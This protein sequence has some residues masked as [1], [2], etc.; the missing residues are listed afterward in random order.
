VIEF[1]DYFQGKTI[2]VTGGTGSIG[3]EIVRQLIQYNPRQIRVY[4]RDEYKQFDMQNNLEVP[5]GARVS[6]LLGDVR[7]KERLFMATEG[8]DII[9]HTAALKHVPYC[10]Y[11]P[12]EAIKTNVLGAQNIAEA[13]RQ[14]N[15]DNVIA[16][17]T[18]KA[19]SP[20]S[21]MGATKLLAE[22]I[23]LNAQNYEG[24]RKTKYSAVRF[25][26]VLGSRGSVVPLFIDQILKKKEITITDP[27]MTRFIM[28]IPE[29]VKLVFNALLL[30][31]G[32]DLFILKMPVVKLIDFARVLI[33]TVS[34]KYNYDKKSID[35][36]IIGKRY[37]EKT[38]ELLFSEEESEY[39]YENNK[40]FCM[41]D[42]ETGKIP[43]GFNKSKKK[44]YNSNSL[45]TLNKLEIKKMILEYINK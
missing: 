8:V 9:F 24:N 27:E 7:D 13:G 26:N 11:N 6:Y 40:M 28:S 45:P 38:Y 23:I 16:I 35:I 30:S 2:L 1:K 36:K 17:S 15:V 3:S 43:K 5:T 41:I 18:D 37:G 12:F 31:R 34:E 25:G 21:T 4:S 32:K 42:S 14:Y 19:A 10:E 20:I 44:S 33:D 29:A 22:K 39:I